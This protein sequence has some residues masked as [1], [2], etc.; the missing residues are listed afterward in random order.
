MAKF[1]G[2]DVRKFILS[3]LTVLLFVGCASGQVDEILGL[4]KPKDDPEVVQ[5]MDAIYLHNQKEYKNPFYRFERYAKEG[6]VLAM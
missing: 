1:W 3:V 5:M 2:S 4:S 6:N